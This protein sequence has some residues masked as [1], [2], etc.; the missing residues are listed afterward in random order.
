MLAF[1][2]FTTFIPGSIK[3]VII[4]STAL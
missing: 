4:I 1:T 2:A 3:G